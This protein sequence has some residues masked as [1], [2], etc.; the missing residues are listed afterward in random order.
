MDS[1]ITYNQTVNQRLRERGQ[2]EGSSVFL[3][4]LQIFFWHILVV[5]AGSFQFFSTMTHPYGKTRVRFPPFVNEIEDK[6]ER[7]G[8]Q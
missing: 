6:I 1:L 3:E 7:V 8:R 2:V 4:Q 5:S